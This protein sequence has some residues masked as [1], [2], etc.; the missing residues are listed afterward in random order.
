MEEAPADYGATEFE[1]RLVNRRSSFVANAQSAEL[2]KPCDAALDHPARLA[3]AAAVRRAALGEFGADAAIMQGI[4]M[5]L[6]IVTTITLHACGLVQRS[7]GFPRQMRDCLDQG[8][9]LRDVV[10]VGLGQ[11][12]AQRNALRV[13]AEMVLA[14]RLAAIG[15]V[16]SS[17]FPP[18]TAR[19]EELSTT[20]RDRSILSAPRSFDN[21]TR[22]SRSHTPAFCHARSPRQQLMPEPQPISWGNISQGMPDC[23]TNKI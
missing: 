13:D 1:E 23:S 15:W 20:T 5:R 2:M 11:D 21:S 12:G 3:Q 8:H 19:T 14:A 7:A 16:R 10:A 17:F 4:A 6:R 9:Q 22:C 18:C